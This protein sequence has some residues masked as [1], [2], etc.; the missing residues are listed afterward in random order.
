[1]GSSRKAAAEGFWSMLR[2]LA[3]GE[4]QVRFAANVALPGGYSFAL[5]VE[6]NI[7]VTP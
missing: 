5:D 7:T 3:P 6:Y 4:H 1:V 2:P